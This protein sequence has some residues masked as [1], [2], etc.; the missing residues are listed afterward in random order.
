MKR[1]IGCSMA[2]MFLMM[3]L[4]MTGCGSNNTAG[5]TDRTK[6]EVAQTELSAQAEDSAQ[7][8]E[9]AQEATSSDIAD[10][11]N[12]NSTELLSDDSKEENNEDGGGEMGDYGEFPGM[13]QSEPGV[14]CNIWVH[15]TGCMVGPTFGTNAAPYGEA[16]Y[17]DG[18]LF[19]DITDYGTGCTYQ[20]EIEKTDSGIRLTVTGSDDPE[21]PGGSVFE[22]PEME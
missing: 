19:F 13:Y 3:T 6:V 7:T 8:A 9:T 21:V 12:G 2:A 18:R 15:M 14:T 16:E 17:R 10:S 4:L 11:G 5:S 20:G 22:M 1:N